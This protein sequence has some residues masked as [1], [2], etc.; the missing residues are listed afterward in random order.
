[1]HV[2]EAGN[3]I[4]IT[5]CTPERCT[6]EILTKT[7]SL[8]SGVNRLKIVGFN[9]KDVDLKRYFTVNHE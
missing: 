1:M 6:D 5:E 8:S 3:V 7:V 9:C 4:T 2:D